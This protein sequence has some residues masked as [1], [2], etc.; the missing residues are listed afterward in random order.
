MGVIFLQI[1][2]PKRHFFLRIA[3]EV[4]SLTQEQKNT[5]IKM[6]SKG[7]SYA[8]IAD[9]LDVSKNTVKTF[10]NRNG[11]GASVAAKERV[12]DNKCK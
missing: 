4:F 7:H 12:D 3:K 10:C 6:R 11:L 2:A 9:T 5:N 1:G 8:V